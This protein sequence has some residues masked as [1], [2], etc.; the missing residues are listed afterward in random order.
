MRRCLLLARR[1]MGRCWPNPPV[2]CVLV[3]EGVPVASARTG[4]GGRPHAEALALAS[5][6][7][8]ASGATAYISLEPCSHEGT[9]PP[10]VHALVEAGIRRAVVALEDLNPRVAGAGLARLREAGIETHAGV[11]RSQ[12][13]E[14]VSGHFS[15][16]GRDRPH[17]TLKIASSL[18]GCVAAADRARTQITGSRARVLVE[19]HRREHDAVLIGSGTARA[20]NPI[21]L[22]TNPGLKKQPPIRVVLDT[23]LSLPADSRLAESTNIAPL[24]LIHGEAA[25]ERRRRALKA[26]GATCIPVSA[27]GS[28]APALSASL[29]TLKERGITRVFCES[30]PKLATT[31]I[32]GEYVDEILWLTAGRTFGNRGLP[33]IAG[34]AVRGFRLREHLLL[35]DD[36]ATYWEPVPQRFGDSG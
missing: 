13:L 33:A 26:S 31:L 4:D 12:A 34:R 16:V 2:G 19:T 17:V 22:P 7:K 29:R 14:L 24:W 27:A 5:A 3:R 10:C 21:L 20:D 6:D 36:L 35:G 11:L 25:S 30:G 15:C 8:R 32:A 1:G 23:D 9:T 18:D 28:E